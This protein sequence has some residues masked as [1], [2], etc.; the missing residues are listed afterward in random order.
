MTV[1]TAQTV[2]KTWNGDI[3]VYMAILPCQIK[4]EKNI[5]SINNDLT[6]DCCMMNF[7]VPL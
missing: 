2:T 6:G 5:L 1:M 4:N 3:C 7:S